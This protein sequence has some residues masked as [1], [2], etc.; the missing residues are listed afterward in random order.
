MRVFLN[1]PF[2]ISRITTHATSAPRRA[3][4]RGGAFHRRRQGVGSAAQRGHVPQR[5]RDRHARDRRLYGNRGDDAPV[6]ERDRNRDAYESRDELLVV[7]GYAL[8]A[9][10]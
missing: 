6:G 8:T 3:C 5:R 10:V 2:Q 7:G 4:L 9:D 1:L